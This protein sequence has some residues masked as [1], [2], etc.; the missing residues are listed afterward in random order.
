MSNVVTLFGPKKKEE[1]EKEKVEEPSFDFSDVV[2]QNQ[3][4]KEKLDKERSQAN[5]GVL[6]SYRIKN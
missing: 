6:R 4:K 2:V 1:D 5:K 3:K